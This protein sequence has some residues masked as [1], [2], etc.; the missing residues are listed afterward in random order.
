MIIWTSPINFI[1]FSNMRPKFWKIIVMIKT[2]SNLLYLKLI[3]VKLLILKILESV[4][5]KNGSYRLITTMKPR[6]PFG[7]RW[8][9]AKEIVYLQTSKYKN[10]APCLMAL[11]TS[12]T[13]L[14]VKP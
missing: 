14:M 11:S 13:M 9:V 7:F 10:R 6:F 8:E 1:K 5:L 4:M 12:A 3:K 2:E